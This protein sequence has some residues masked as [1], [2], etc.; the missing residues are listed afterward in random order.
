M[1]A[2]NEM[3]N[4]HLNLTRQTLQVTTRKSQHISQGNL[5]KISKHNIYFSSKDCI[6]QFYVAIVKTK[7]KQYILPQGT[8]YKSM[9][10][11]AYG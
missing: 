4:Q 11:N 7:R 1:L 2:Q 6:T 5:F 9:D 3:S 10:Q 8:N